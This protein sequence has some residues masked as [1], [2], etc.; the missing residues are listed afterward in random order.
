MLFRAFIVF[1]QF[2][3]LDVY[4]KTVR[5]ND[6]IFELFIAQDVIEKAIDKI[7]VDIS[8]DMKDKNPL[9]ICVLNGS[10]MFASELMKRL[11]IP[12]EITF[13]K[14]SSY[15]GLASSGNVKEVYGLE[16]NIEGRTVIIV[17][18]IIDTGNTM[19][20]MLKQ[21]NAKNPKE[22]KVSTLLLKP[23]SLVNELK[24]DYVAMSIPSDFIVGYGLDYDGYGRNYPDIYK[25][26]N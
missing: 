26:K 2:I 25:I 22:I 19:V 6:K 20:Q 4:M 1:L 12:A 17:E 9:F 16:E 11:N 21:L 8:R 24:I 15:A 13:V 3:D 14:M 23:D 10:F 5:I 18:D 7:A